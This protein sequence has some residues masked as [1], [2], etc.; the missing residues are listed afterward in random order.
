MTTQPKKKRRR[1]IWILAII[2]I[3]FMLGKLA[4]YGEANMSPEDRAR[5]DSLRAETDS[6]ERANQAAEAYRKEVEDSKLLLRYYTK[7]TVKQALKAPS[8]AKFC[9]YREFLIQTH[10]DSLYTIRGY[11]DA[12]NSFGAMI[13]NNFTVQLR[14]LGGD[15]F[16]VVGREIR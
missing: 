3:F 12:Q 1:W 11:V 7:E 6:L 16:R 13:R 15:R 10:S 5:I 4:E 2:A 8:T 9:K 14:W